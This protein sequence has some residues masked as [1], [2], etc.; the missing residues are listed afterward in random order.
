M[1][2][3]AGPAGDVPLLHP[4][5]HVVKNDGLRI[6]SELNRLT[7]ERVIVG[8]TLSG[9]D[10]DCLRIYGI[11]TE[12]I[13]EWLPAEHEHCAFILG[14]KVFAVWTELQV[15]KTAAQRRLQDRLVG[16]AADLLLRQRY[17]WSPDW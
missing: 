16:Y 6:R 7:G 17:V 10:L 15:V 12:K 11:E 8:F 3:R 1:N 13:F 2:P 5:L 14:N 4:Q 9:L